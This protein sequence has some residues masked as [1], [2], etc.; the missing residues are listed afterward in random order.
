MGQFPR[1]AKGANDHR[2]KV[3]SQV[4]R[5]NRWVR[6]A[7]T[8]VVL[9]WLASTADPA[10]AQDYANGG[11][12]A[13]VVCHGAGMPQPAVA[14]F[15]TPHGSRVDPQAPFAKLQCEQCHGPSAAH[16]EAM[17]RGESALPPVV[18]GMAAQTPAADQN[19]ACLAC[20]DDPG[21]GGRPGSAHELGDIPC[22]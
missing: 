4:H 10:L 9:Q 11:A 3:K 7:V 1:A 15:A 16:V 17:Q 6:G 14:I 20:H 13:C 5:W 18:F 2:P 22:A 19:G 12:D 21:G 8:L